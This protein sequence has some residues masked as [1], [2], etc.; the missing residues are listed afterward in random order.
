M[1]AE[2]PVAYHVNVHAARSRHDFIPHD[3]ARHGSR[4]AQPHNAVEELVGAREVARVHVLIR[5]APV[6]PRP[7]R[8]VRQGVGKVDDG[9]RVALLDGARGLS[10]DPN[11]VDDVGVTWRVAERIAAAGVEPWARH[12]EEEEEQE[13]LP[14]VGWSVVAP[15]MVMATF[16]AQRHFSTDQKSVRYV[17]STEPDSY[18]ITQSFAS[19]VHLHHPAHPLHDR[20]KL[21]PKHQYLPV[22]LAELS[23]MQPAQT[24]ELDLA[25]LPRLLDR[26]L[27]H[28]LPVPGAFLGWGRVDGGSRVG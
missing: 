5:P 22:L 18:D 4:E 20:V 13:G 9:G 17:Y 12:Q 15:V 19:S 26:S 8:R 14:H 7:P 10:A 27:Q 16:Q 2:A 23:F 6:P 25:I 21:L 24:V 28:G 1:G 3:V 11:L